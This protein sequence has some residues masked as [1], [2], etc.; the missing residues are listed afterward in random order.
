MTISFETPARIEANDR[1]SSD[2]PFNLLI[3]RLSERAFLLA[4]FHCGAEM[5]DFEG[6]AKDSENVKTIKNKIR[7]VDWE[8]YSSRQ[9]TKMKFGG[10][11]GDITYKGDFQKYLQLLRLGEHIHVGK[12][13]TFGLGKYRIV[14]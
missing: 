13:A 4:H 14:R 6:F 11:V 5:R 3:R 9:Q 12:A 7:W 8:R 2:I 10:L 1:L